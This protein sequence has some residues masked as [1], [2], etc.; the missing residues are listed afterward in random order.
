MA[1][2]PSRTR[3]ERIN[4]SRYGADVNFSRSIDVRLG[5]FEVQEIQKSPINSFKLASFA[6]VT[7]T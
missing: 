5:D 2:T 1:G 6:I 7:R 3:A 4:W